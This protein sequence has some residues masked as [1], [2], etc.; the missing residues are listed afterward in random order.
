MRHFVSLTSSEEG[1]APN[2]GIMGRISWESIPTQHR[3]LSN[4]HAIVFS[5]SAME[6]T[7]HTSVV[8]DQLLELLETRAFHRVFVAGGSSIYELLLPY[9]STI[10]YTNVVEQEGVVIPTDTRSQGM[11]KN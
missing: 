11:C 4:R 3:P 8:R 7:A 1:A 6:S 9:T 2:A 5:N 10:H